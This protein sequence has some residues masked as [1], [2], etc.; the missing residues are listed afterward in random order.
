MSDL[1]VILAQKI[2]KSKEELVTNGVIN[3]METAT[4]ES[5]KITKLVPVDAKEIKAEQLI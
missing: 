3:E 4:D 5:G 2:E 1:K